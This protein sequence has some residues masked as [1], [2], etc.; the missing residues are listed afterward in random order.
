MSFRDDNLIGG[1]VIVY[2]CFDPGNWET[3]EAPIVTSQRL[4]WGPSFSEIAGTPEADISDSNSNWTWYD[5]Q[6]PGSKNWVL[7]SNPNEVE[8]YAEV[9]IKGAIRWT[10]TILPYQNKTPTFSGVMGGPVEVEAWVSNIDPQTQ[11][12]KKVAPAPVFAS[13]RVLWNGYFNE[14]VGKG[15]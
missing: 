9:R 14:I 1:P 15:M 5:Q 13:Q 4:I 6:S 10:G 8:I 11:L 2:G 3:T 12:Q 7:V